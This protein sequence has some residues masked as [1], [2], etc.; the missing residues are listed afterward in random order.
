MDLKL[1]INQKENTNMSSL[2]K[3]M[4]NLKCRIT[5]NVEE[6][7]VT[8][9]DIPDTNVDGV[10]D[11]INDAFSITGMDITPTVIQP[12]PV[13]PVITADSLEFDKIEFSDKDVESQINKLMK[14]IYWAMY[15]CNAQS[16]D[17]CQYIISTNVEIA[18]KYNPKPICN[19]SVGDIVDCTYGTHLSGEISGGHI[20]SIV[21]NIDPGGTVY[22]VPITKLYR[23]GPNFISFSA[24]MDVDYY[25][26][27]YSGGT[28]L[29]K[30]GRYIRPE[31]IV[32]VLGHVHPELF[33]RVLAELPKMVSF[34]YDDYEQTW[35]E[36]IGDIQNDDNML[37][38]TGKT[39]SDIKAENNND[40][41][42]E[43]TADKNDANTLAEGNT[44]KLSVY[45]YLTSLI[46]DSLNNLDKSISA[47]EQ[48]DTFLCSIG[49]PNNESVVKKAFVV[50]SD[51]KKITYENIVLALVGVYPDSETINIKS[52]LQSEF[53]K[54][55]VNYPELKE[56]YPTVS[57]IT[58]IKVFAKSLT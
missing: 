25:N 51:I 15:S 9:L 33:N 14:N 42:S 7:I 11:A 28:I 4:C 40:K 34:S 23:E 2:V 20:H 13:E 17:I 47:E 41:I 30:K 49:F 46:S 3:Q 58:L 36:H 16:R 55:I 8:M 39:E 32:E 18:M 19:F 29:L 57:I 37:D 27:H 31:R 24:N 52:T 6:G 35:A 10:I 38:F 1:T 43:E 22:V 44:G 12:E 54:W 48:I 50:A 21:C 56:K 53:N 45:D 26:P 5:V